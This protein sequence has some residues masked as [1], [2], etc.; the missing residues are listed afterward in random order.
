MAAERVFYGETGQ[1]VG[2]DIAGA[3]YD[4]AFMVGT[5]GMA[6]ER[7][8]L[9]DR[10][11]TVAETEAAERKLMRRYEQV[12]VRIMNRAS[13]GSP[14]DGDPV[15]S[16]LGDPAKRAM[17][18]QLLGQAFLTAYWF[19]SHN[20][21]ATDRVA[22]VLVEKRT[23]R[24]RCHRPARQRGPDHPRHRPA[25]R[26]ELA[27]NL[28]SG[29]IPMG[30]FSGT[31]FERRFRLAYVGLALVVLATAVLIVVL[32]TQTDRPAP[33]SSFTAK[34]DD[35]VKRAQESRH[36][37]RGATFPPR[38]TGAIG[39]GRGRRGRLAQASPAQQVV[40]VG[41]NPPGLVSYE[42]GGILFF[43]MCAA[44]PECALGPDQSPDVLAPILAREAHELA[45][46]GLKYVPEAKFVITIL[47]PGF[48][49]GA[50]PKE[51]SARGPLLPPR[52]S[53][54]GARP[55]GRHH[56]PGRAPDPSHADPG[57]GHGD[58]GPGD[59]DSLHA[60]LRGGRRQHPEHLHA[61]APLLARRYSPAVASAPPLRASLRAT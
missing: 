53:R 48:V 49:S 57:A 28:E 56:A 51:P 52:R 23:V 7:P 44:G 8:R 1:G 40:A 2:G 33:F 42:Y 15:A 9:S 60:Q 39:P 17:V 41:T 35:P 11:P 47:P 14:L 3:T 5:W 32:A 59:E 46:Y 37:S 24:Q 50:D 58:R 19:V 13:S 16:V 26:G 31:T 55:A 38:G 22:E 6:P 45:L 25:G 36:M 61:D 20:K 34:D 29:P 54:K 18:A 4:A 21:A 43:R 10:F 12:G 27:K 30:T